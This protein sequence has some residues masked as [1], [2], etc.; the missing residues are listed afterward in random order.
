MTG[1]DSEEEP[2]KEPANG[3]EDS[4]EPEIPQRIDRKMPIVPGKSRVFEVSSPGRR[5]NGEYRIF[6][7]RREDG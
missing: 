4:D 3:T 2:H 1:E 6:P 5:K 7:K